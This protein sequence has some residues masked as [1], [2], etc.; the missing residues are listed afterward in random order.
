MLLP[1]DAG[2]DEAS[3]V[4]FLHVL[5][6]IARADAS[7][8]WCLCQASVCSMSATT[9]RRDIAAAMFDDPSA[10]LCWGSGPPGRAIRVEGGWRIGGEWAMASGSLHATWMG[11]ACVIHDAEGAALLEDDGLPAIR[12]FLFPA[13]QATM[14][15]TWNVIGL[16]GTGSHNYALRD[17]FVADA[18]VFR[19][20]AMPAPLFGGPLYRL[21]Q[22]SLWSGGDAII[23]LGIARGALDALIDLARAKTPLGAPRAML[24]SALVQA[25]IGRASA[26]LEAARVYLYRAVEDVWRVL[27]SG[28]AMELKHR[29]A[30]RAAA[31]RAIEEAASIVDQC[32]REAGTSAIFEGSPFERRFRDVHVIAQHLHAR[33]AHF[34]SVGQYVLGLEPFAAFM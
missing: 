30:I 29:V 11:A 23:A 3:P 8:A 24:D 27:V 19:R 28:G 32:Y 13:A 22:N 12:T 18:Y 16:R 34:E 17:L 31:S 25:M 10:L 14:L 9:L 7:V 6:T 5:E 26:R 21:P 1:R 15:D 2:G 20:Q 33:A 4:A